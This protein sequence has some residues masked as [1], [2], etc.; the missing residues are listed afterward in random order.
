LLFS[1]ILITLGAEIPAANRLKAKKRSNLRIPK[2]TVNFLF[3][4]I[5]LLLRI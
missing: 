2:G 5:T 4:C 1:F 3:W